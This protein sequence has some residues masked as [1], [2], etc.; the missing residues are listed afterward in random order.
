M[1][2]CL[3]FDFFLYFSLN[4]T[5]RFGT[6]E[7]RCAMRHGS[8]RPGFVPVTTNSV[9]LRGMTVSE[10]F[11]SGF[12]RPSS[13]LSS[14]LCFQIFFFFNER[15]R[16]RRGPPIESSREGANIPHAKSVVFFG[17]H[18]VPARV[19]L[20]FSYFS[21]FLLGHFNYWRAFKRQMVSPTFGPQKIPFV[22]Q[23]QR[24]SK[25]AFF[26]HFP[27]WTSLVSD[28]RDRAKM[29]FGLHATE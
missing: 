28:Q 2:V 24:R 4:D 1:V 22:K 12:F 7:F 26:A 6:H 17:L 14:P 8:C 25:R 21:D 27:H 11:I 10:I 18:W 13:P 5:T 9:A 29:I 23:K 3:I 15:P 19:L 20:Q 16:A